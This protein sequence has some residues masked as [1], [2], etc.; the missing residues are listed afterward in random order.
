MPDDVRG[1]LERL[2]DEIRHHAD[3]YHVLDA[4][5]IS[6]AEY[7]ALLREL[8]Q[9]EEAHADLVTPDSPTQRVGGHARERFTKVQHPTPILSLGNAFTADDVRAWHARLQRLLPDGLALQFVVEPK[10]D[11]LTVVLHYVNGLFT[12]GATRGNGE[13][14]EDITLNLRTTASVPLRIPRSTASVPAP[15]RLVVRGEAFMRISDFQA[16]NRSQE[17]Q[18]ARTF[19]N[20]RNAAAGSFRQLDPAI[21]AAR[22]LRCFFYAVVDSDGVGFDTQWAV[23][24]YLRNVGFPV[25]PDGRCFDDLEEAI[26][27]AE[28]WMQGRKRLD[29]EVDGVVFKVN[30]LATQR[31]LGVV[32]KD[33]RAKIAFK[34]P[35]RRTTTQLIELGINVGRTGALTPFAILEPVQLGGVTIERA[36]LHNFEDIARRDIRVG[37]TVLIKRAGD[38]IPQV[39]KPV[40]QLRTGDEK[41]ITV[42]EQCPVCG[43]LVVKPQGEVTIYCPNPSC[44]AQ[45]VQRIAY[46]AAVMDIEGLG[47]RL[48]QLLVDQDL[49][50]DPADLYYLK[51]EDIVDLPGFADKSTDNLLAAVESS[52]D[53]PLH[54][55]LAALGIR[56]VG[57][58]VAEV[59]AQH[60]F[61]ILV[62]MHASTEELEGI[63]GLGPVRASSIKGFFAN[64]S[65]RRMVKRLERAGVRVQKEV[66]P[67]RAS[68]PLDGK[69]FVITGT[70]PVMTRGEAGKL[71]KEHGGKVATSVSGRTDY[72]LLGE[73]PGSKYAKA[74]ELG[75][76][77]INEAQLRQMMTGGTEPDRSE[78][79]TLL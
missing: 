47:E 22:P 43:T 50:H 11:G 8:R 59:L 6:D 51:R 35:A 3:L 73:S 31:S 44:P 57:I 75:V 33:P 67:E 16:F 24:Q 76:A 78:Q 56:G 40:A 13:V 72:L 62:L 42:P 53:R 55:T 61:S 71:I 38:V 64:D 52:K 32:G 68:R 54:R 60:F 9:L 45:V 39:E 25:N 48:I 7:D 14:G 18:G 58:T 27:Y 15:R 70:L 26:A 2:R 17:E 23:L 19:A 77:I 34:F 41:V 49:L 79:G 10:I 5:E 66:D 46:W 28:A 12:L 63:T 29:Y 21:T 20:P 65:A 74:Q 4:P 36:T 37:D 30:D 69:T 1:R